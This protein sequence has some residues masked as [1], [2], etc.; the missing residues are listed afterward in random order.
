MIL[1]FLNLPSSD[2]CIITPSYFPLLMYA[3][4]IIYE[5]FSPSLFLELIS[6]PHTHLPPRGY[7]S[8]VNM[9]H[10][11][12]I[13]VK[14]YEIS[15]SQPSLISLVPN[16]YF[17]LLT[18]YIYLNDLQIST[19]PMVLQNFFSLEYHCLDCI[20]QYVKFK[21]PPEFLIFPYI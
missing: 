20:C 2:F 1:I 13:Y 11:Q 21:I 6:P 16:V 9:D 8:H 7:F 19:C 4:P 15:E 5:M 17:Q 3:T 10:Y 18:G 14:I 12:I